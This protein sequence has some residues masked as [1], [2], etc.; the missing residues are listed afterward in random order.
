MLESSTGQAQEPISTSLVP[1]RQTQAPQESSAELID[2]AAQWLAQVRQSS[3]EIKESSKVKQDKSFSKG[4]QSTLNLSKNEEAEARKEAFVTKRGE[5][6]PSTYAPDKP[7][8]QGPRPPLKEASNNTSPGYGNI[9]QKKIETIIREEAAAR[10][11][12]P[13]VAVAIFR[14][15]GAGNY[16]S[17]IARS[18]KGA[19]GGKEA[20]YG[21]YQLY[22]GGGLGNQYQQKTGRDLRQDNTEEGVANQIRFALDAAVDQGWSPWYGRKHAGVGVRDGLAG[23]IKL[24]NWQ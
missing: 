3:N 16:Q 11:M 12:D 24:G 19:E 18:G 10:K 4:F 6:R 13:D 17:Q 23:A 7:G 2:R 22:T 8:E 15:E 5:E 21:P 20:S 1:V 9:S 14:S